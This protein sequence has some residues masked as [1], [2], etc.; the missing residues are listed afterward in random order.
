MQTTILGLNDIEDLNYLAEEVLIRLRYEAY[1]YD[2]NGDE[3]AF[4]KTENSP[5]EERS[6]AV[7]EW[8]EK[9]KHNHP[10]S[11]RGNEE[12]MEI[13]F[14]D[15]LEI[16]FDEIKEKY[17]KDYL[18]M[19]RGIMRKDTMLIGLAAGSEISDEYLDNLMA[20]RYKENLKL[21]TIQWGKDDSGK[22]V[23]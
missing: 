6:E 5:H 8:A 9:V 20:L 3:K 16:T 17:L 7:I 12:L 22:S 21:W 10:L 11:F 4:S 2:E 18:P 19:M 15:A 1:R 23:L 14:T 13:P